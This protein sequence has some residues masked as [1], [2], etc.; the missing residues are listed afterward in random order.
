MC[1]G[2][3]MHDTVD[4]KVACEGKEMGELL[5]ILHEEFNKSGSQI[6]VCVCGVCID[7][8]SIS[9]VVPQELSALIFETGSVIWIWG[10][11]I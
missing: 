2:L 6:S 10:S 1:K 3:M 7:Q 5:G 11:L 4:T 9:C 8:G